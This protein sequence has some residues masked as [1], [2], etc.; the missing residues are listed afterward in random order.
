MQNGYLLDTNICI[1]II[2]HKPEKVI[3]RFLKLDPKEICISSITFA[4]LSYGAEKS[5]EKI[6]NHIALTLFLSN[7]EIKSFDMKAAEEYGYVRA[8]LE[9]KGLPI[10]PLDT[11]IAAHARS[12]GLI[13]VTN[14]TREFERVEG[15]KVENWVG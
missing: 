13:L 8:E 14:N 1:Y 2:K 12:L 6:K 11:E 5:L 7:L 4:E 15:L 10:G 9:T 3:E